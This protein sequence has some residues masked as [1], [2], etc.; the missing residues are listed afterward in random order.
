MNHHD[1]HLAELLQQSQIRPSAILGRLVKRRQWTAMMLSLMMPGLGQIYLG[2]G[3]QGLFFW[4]APNAMVIYCFLYTDASGVLA[5]LFTLAGF[6]FM[7]SARA[8]LEAREE[9][10]PPRSYNHPMIYM[11]LVV[12]HLSIPLLL[13]NPH[14]KLG[15]RVVV[16]AFAA[17]T[18]AMEPAIYRRELFFVSKTFY[19]H[20]PIRLG[21]IVTIRDPENEGKYQIR[22]IV[23]LPG[24]Q[25]RI[26]DGR[27]DGNPQK[28][29][30][31]PETSLRFREHLGGRAYVVTTGAAP[32][33][34]E[35]QIVTVPNEHYYVMA[36]HRS[37][38]RDSR[39]WG[40]LPRSEIVGRAS[41]ILWPRERFDRIG[42]LD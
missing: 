8:F 10:L 40:P 3:R 32:T 23:A 11:L 28:T 16:R 30:S 41:F 15:S 31:P 38:Y 29:D 25:I 26:R 9:P 22:R 35:E 21:D 13:T 20:N 37:G 18:N 33:Q 42:F 1:P 12:L 27:I 34:T 4:L 36:D 5:A 17:T 14:S 2:R 19:R 7:S 24:Q 6:Y 39:D